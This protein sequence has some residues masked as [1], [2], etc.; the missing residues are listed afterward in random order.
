MWRRSST[1]AMCADRESQRPKYGRN[2]PSTRRRA[3][4]GPGAVR[5]HSTTNDTS[6]PTNTRGGACTRSESPVGRSDGLT[7]SEARS[8]ATSTEKST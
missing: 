1:A 4:L 8:I 7:S 2:G 3:V 6:A 5:V